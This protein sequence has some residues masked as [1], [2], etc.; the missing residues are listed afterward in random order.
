MAD[1]AWNYWDKISNDVKRILRLAE[2]IANN[3][4]INHVTAAHIML[5]LI[6]TYPHE[7]KRVIKN[8][9]LSDVTNELKNKLIYTDSL[10]KKDQIIK[11]A[12]FI[13]NFGT[14]KLT[15]IIRISA[16]YCGLNLESTGTD[17]AVYIKRETIEKPESTLFKKFIKEKQKPDPFL[18]KFGRDLTQLAITDKLHPIIG[19]STEINLVA[20]TLCRVIK[21]NPLLVGPA[22]VGKTAIVEGLAQKLESDNITP[23]L[24]G[25]R[26]VE[27]NVG[28]LI[29][30]TKYRGDFENRLMQIIEKVKNTHFILFI[31]ELHTLFGAGLAEGT[32]LDATNMLLP[33]LARGEIACIGATTDFNYHKYIEKDKAFERRFQPIRV[34]PLSSAET[35]DMLQKIGPI[36]FEKQKKIKIDPDVY[37]ASIDLAERYMK[38]R[39]F[40]DKALDIIDQAVGR[41]LRKGNKKITVSEIRDVI[42]SLTGIPVGKLENEL[43]NKLNGLT[44]HLKEKIKGQDH[45]ADIVVDTIW[46][47]TLGVD[48][49]P[50]RPNGVFL[51]IGPTGVGKTEFARVLAQYLFGSF[52]KLIRIDMSEYSEPQSVA[53]LLGA[54][55]GYQGH[56][57]GSPILNEIKEKPFSILLLDEIEKAHPDIHKLF[58]QVY[59][60]GVLTD[61][62]RD[63]VYFSDV[64]IIMTSNIPVEKDQSIGFLSDEK[65]KQTR[66]KLTT[67]FPPEFLNRIDY[68][69]VFNK[70]S[71]KVAE[72]IVNNK[73]IPLIKDKWKEKNIS[74]EISSEVL[75]FIVEKGF[76]EKWGARNLERTV[77]TLISSPLAKFLQDVKEKK[78]TKVK[79]FIENGTIQFKK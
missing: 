79:I 3:A 52:D 40:P 56:E 21:R 29:R 66:D 46:P 72:D 57:K 73:I 4:K 58:L 54:P 17:T 64:I 25:I 44:S 74:F 47:K 6:R 12:L 67:Y 59:D 41:T 71:K 49:R 18:N 43:K 69:C 10:T 31:D 33:S 30:G 27:I 37:Y 20:E 55:F 34:A 75:S 15:H 1:P 9:P 26:I 23:E 42:G 11:D 22:G 16:G 61:T 48:L 76:S 68:I 28:N 36:E 32:T 39:H 70:L 45:V 5:A 35:L 78:N 38:N 14:V 53:K 62:N 8:I 2:S 63:H 13:A 77:D 24:Q 51:F 7:V 65:S 19:R 50:E 60:T